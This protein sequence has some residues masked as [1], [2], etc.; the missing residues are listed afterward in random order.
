MLRGES[1]KSMCIVGSK[2]PDHALPSNQKTV[3][4]SERPYTNLMQLYVET[5]I[6]AFDWISGSQ[7]P[8]NVS[9]KLYNTLTEA[10]II[11]L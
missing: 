11:T 9:T 10:L 6:D 1:V 5:E 3:D 8:S 4:R 7:N 2:D